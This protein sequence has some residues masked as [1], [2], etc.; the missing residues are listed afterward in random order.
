MNTILLAIMVLGSEGSASR[1]IVVEPPIAQIVWQ[2]VV[3]GVKDVWTKFERRGTRDRAAFGDWTSPSL[4]IYGRPRSGIIAWAAAANRVAG[5]ILDRRTDGSVCLRFA[6]RFRGFN[7]IR[8]DYVA[9]GVIRLTADAY[10]SV[11]PRGELYHVRL[12]LLATERREGETAITGTATGWSHIG[13]RCR[14]VRRIAE[15]RITDAM[16]DAL[17]TI[18]AGGRGLYANGNIYAI[19]TEFVEGLR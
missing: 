11:G 9:D 1:E 8:E 2:C 19:V 6:Y 10:G 15:P 16:R 14:L 18:D 7:I 13:D 5:Y 3:G 4:R 17:A 12:V